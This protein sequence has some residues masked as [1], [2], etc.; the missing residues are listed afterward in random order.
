[1]IIR[2]QTKQEQLHITG[3]DTL[4]NCKK[5]PEHIAEIILAYQNDFLDLDEM[6]EA[7]LGA[8][9]IYDEKG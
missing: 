6:K 4:I 3:Y 8:G 9:W 5:L 7:L 1:M 2:E